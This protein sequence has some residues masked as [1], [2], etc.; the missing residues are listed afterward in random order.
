M[1][2]ARISAAVANVW[3]QPRVTA[4]ERLALNNHGLGPWLDQLSDGDTVALER[5]N[6]IV[7]Q[8]LFN[9]PFIV[10]RIVDGWAFGYVATQRDARHPE[11]YPGWVWAAQLSL[12][13]LPLRTGTTVTVKR[14]FTPLLRPDGSTLRRLSLGTELPVISSKDHRYDLVQ[15]PLGVGKVAKRATQFQFDE[16]HLLAGAQMVRLGAE[17]LD[18]RY[19]WGGVSAYGFDCSGLV[20]SLH[21]AVGIQL[22]RDASDQCLVGTTV[23]LANAQPGDLCFFAHDHGQ[24]AVHHVAMY[25]GDGW[26]LHAPTPGKHVT[27]LQLATTYLR[28]ELVAVKRNW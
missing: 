24:G 11:G 26:L 17:F 12:A 19:L 13:P 27:Y 20:Y 6:R 3:R 23:D 5:D 15:T 4:L 21:R 14:D 25:A 9:D 18:L 1:Q 2:T 7:T 8:A 28:D 10:D 16:P 22:P